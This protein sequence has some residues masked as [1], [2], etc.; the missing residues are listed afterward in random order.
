MKVHIDIGITF[1]IGKEET[2]EEDC[3]N[4]LYY[5]GPARFEE[6]LEA[7]SE[8]AIRNYVRSL[9]VIQIRDMKSEQA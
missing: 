4:F 9:K 6:F 1:H 2:L 8:E 3:R 5:L 7:E